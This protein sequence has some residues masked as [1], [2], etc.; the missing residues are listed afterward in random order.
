VYN[1]LRKQ[2]L[3]TDAPNGLAKTLEHGTCNV[4]GRSDAEY[5]VV[6]PDQST[7]PPAGGANQA[8][9]RRII[10]MANLQSKHLA[11]K[12]TADVAEANYKARKDELKACV[13]S[14]KF[15]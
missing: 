9:R 2:T 6:S 1:E 11:L 3:N 8:P 12:I 7:T 10:Y 14:L 13:K 15:E 4:A 5:F